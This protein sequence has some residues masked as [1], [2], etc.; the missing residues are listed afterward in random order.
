MELFG[1]GVR[2]EEDG[3]L[4]E[5]LEAFTRSTE[6]RPSLAE[7]WWNRGVMLQRLGRR[8]DADASFEEARALGYAPPGEG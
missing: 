1:Q 8:A 4:E 7:S 2:L 6:L 5:A 3:L